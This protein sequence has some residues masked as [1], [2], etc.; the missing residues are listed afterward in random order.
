MRANKRLIEWLLY[1]SGCSD[2]R[3]SKET[4]FHQGNLSRLKNNDKSKIEAMS[5]KNAIKLSNFA[6]LYLW[7]D[8]NGFRDVFVEYRYENEE[9]EEDLYDVML[10]LM[11]R[12]VSLQRF[13][14]NRLAE[15]KSYDIEKALINTVEMLE[16]ALT[17]VEE[18]KE[19][20]LSE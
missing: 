15:E 12:G 9:L 4:G 20:D 6:E 7:Q 13:T 1:E 19:P 8:L 11:E 18:G 5:F 3:I 16:K 14:F 17:D 2:Y 10:E